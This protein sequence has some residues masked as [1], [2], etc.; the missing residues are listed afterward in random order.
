[1]TEF[2]AFLRKAREAY[3]AC[4][5]DT[6]EWVLDRGPLAGG[7]INTKV[8]SISLKDYG[9]EDGWRG[10]DYTYGWI[11]GRGLEALVTHAAFFEKED[12]ALAAR[13]DAAARQ[14]YA[15]LAPLY[16]RYGGAF[17]CYDASMTPVRRDS[18]GRP[19][20]QNTGTPYF[21]YSD[22]FVLKGL[23]AATTRY[24]VARRAPYLAKMAALVE[25]TENGLFI[26][27][28]QL[29]LT[30][31][32]AAAQEPEFGPRM[33]LMGAAGM[34]T[35]LG[36]HQEASFGDRYIAH[37]LERHWD[38]EGENPSFL[39]RDIEGGDRCNVGHAIEL[40]GFSYEY[41]PATAAPETID[42]IRLAMLSS[43][44]AA[45]TEPGLCLHVSAASGERISPYFPWWSLP[46]T[47]RAASLCYLRRPDDAVLATWQKAHEAF[48]AN[49]WRAEH[50]LAYQTR[51]RQGP[52]DFVPATPDLDPGYHTG[53]SLLAAIHAC[54][55][56]L[57]A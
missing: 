26:G 48:F 51:D 54:D 7:F 39:I 8:N 55:E 3:V 29:P 43:F 19:V 6:L 25:G 13:L 47:V 17:F 32:S 36:L 50:A 4:N 38:K 37:V 40:A 2:K 53:L 10:P 15:V 23:I 1:M 34:L 9:S 18:E 28:E 14:L 22:A 30:A 46:E 56:L 35:Q 20:P 33:I 44:N 24:D 52:V 41:L 42:N 12:P 21:T 16:E 57:K 11:Q 5:R 49:Y 45:F 31:E 27:D